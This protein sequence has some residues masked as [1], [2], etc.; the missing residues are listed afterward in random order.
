MA[1]GRAEEQ[2]AGTGVP[3]ATV[4]TRKK[5]GEV[6]DGQAGLPGGLCDEGAS[7]RVDRLRKLWYRLRIEGR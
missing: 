1:G 2:G 6:C 5:A 7:A 3:T 4:G